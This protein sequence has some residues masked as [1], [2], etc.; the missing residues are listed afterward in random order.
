MRS[1]ISA[2]LVLTMGSATAVLAGAPSPVSA[3]RPKASAIEDLG[4]Y[5]ENAYD[6]AKV[7]DWTKARASVEALKAAAG[8]LGPAERKETAL[9]GQLDGA[10]SAL[11]KAVARRDK[12]AAMREANLLTRLDAELSR[13][14]KPVVP[15]DV[16]LLDYY[17]RELDIWASARDEAKLRSTVVGMGTTWRGLRP[18]VLA[19]GASAVASRFDSLVKKAESTRGVDELARLSTPILDE[20]DN[21]EHAFTGK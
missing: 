14:S 19:R 17:G 15:A 4:H 8:R 1:L 10:L 2:V 9:A 5:A 3:T 12:P 20:V 13:P 18:Q 11:D 21:L 6:Q 7:A 16:T